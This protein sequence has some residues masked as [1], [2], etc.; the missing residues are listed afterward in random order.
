MLPICQWWVLPKD[1]NDILIFEYTHNASAFCFLNSQLDCKR[2]SSR[3]CE[4]YKS[5]KHF[6]LRIFW[7]TRTH[8]FL[9]YEFLWHNNFMSIFLC[10]VNSWEIDFNSH[11][12]GIKG[13]SRVLISLAITK[14]QLIKKIKKVL[15]VV[16]HIQ[17][18]RS[19]KWDLFF[20]LWIR[21]FKSFC[22]KESNN[23]SKR[24]TIG[25][26]FLGKF[27][28]QVHKV[29]ISSNREQFCVCVFVALFIDFIYWFFVI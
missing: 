12:L 11:Q 16:S 3:N 4:S 26:D 22:Q 10:W 8:G 14:F 7:C 2:L 19:S 24:L 23:S 27:Y 21:V 1:L 9:I 25:H 5:T 29:C 15:S 28:G 13:F 18:P 20:A 17:E 6:S